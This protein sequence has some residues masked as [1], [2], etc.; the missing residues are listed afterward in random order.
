MELQDHQNTLKMTLMILIRVCQLAGKWHGPILVSK[1]I[2]LALES[3]SEPFLDNQL[4]LF[5]RMNRF[6]N[7]DFFKKK[8]LRIN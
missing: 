3:L 4:K 8:S 6:E 5:F 7:K 1:F 2:E